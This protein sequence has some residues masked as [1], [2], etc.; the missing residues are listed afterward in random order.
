MITKLEKAARAKQRA[1]R[2]IDDGGGGG[3]TK[4]ENPLTN[5]Y[6]VNEGEG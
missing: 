1:C 5:A 3:G 2:A 4:S 6:S